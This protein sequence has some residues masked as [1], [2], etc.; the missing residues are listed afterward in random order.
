[1]VELISNECENDEEM[2]FVTLTERQKYIIEILKGFNKF[3]VKLQHR[4]NATSLLLYKFQ[5]VQHLNLPRTG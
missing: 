1:M 3:Q 2:S 4:R 5:K